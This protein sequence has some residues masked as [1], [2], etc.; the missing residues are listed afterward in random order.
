M[1]PPRSRPPLPGSRHP[2]GQDPPGADPPEADTPLGADPHPPEQTPREQTPPKSRHPPQEQTHPPGSRL[3]HTVY[4]RPVR[5]LL[6]CIL[7]LVMVRLYSHKRDSESGITS[8]W[9]Q[10]DSNLM[11]TL[12]S[13]QDTKIKKKLLSLRMKI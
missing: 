13:D 7:V 4:E 9:V 12:S 10:R 1:P 5:M 6:G 8:R 11:F 3:Q 2:P